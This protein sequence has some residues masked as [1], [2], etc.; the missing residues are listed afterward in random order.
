MSWA[1]LCLGGAAV[2]YGAWM[3]VIYP[4]GGFFAVWLVLGAL[5]LAAGIAQRMGAWAAM[6]VLLRPHQG[7]LSGQPVVVACVRLVRQNNC[8]RDSTERR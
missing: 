5:L 8:R 4:A 3:G 1:L 6:P 7:C 2:A